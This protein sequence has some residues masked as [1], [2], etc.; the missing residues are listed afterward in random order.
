MGGRSPRVQA[1]VLTVLLSTACAPTPEIEFNEPPVAGIVDLRPDDPTTDQDLTALITEEATDPDGDDLRLTWTFTRNGTAWAVPGTT[2]PM[3]ETARGQEWAVTVVASDGEWESAPFSDSVIIA[4]S[5]PVVLSAAFEDTSPTTRDLLHVV[6]EAA[7]ADDDSLAW[8]TRWTVDGE[9]YDA[10]ADALEVAS[11]ATSAG[12]TWS[13]SVAA[14]DG[15]DVGE[16]LTASVTIANTGPVIESV[17]I[18]PSEPTVEDSIYASVL[19]LFDPDDADDVTLTV[20]W[21]IDG[22]LTEEDLLAAPNN[23]TSL[24]TDVVRGQSLQVTA[25]PA[26]GLVTGD[27]LTSEAVTVENALPVLGYVD[28]SPPDGDELTVFTCS[29]ESAT[30]ADGDEI[31]LDIDWWVSGS[32]ASSGAE[33]LDGEDFDKGDELYCEVTPRDGYDEGASVRS[34]TASISN[35]LPEFTSVEISPSSPDVEDTVSAAT[36]GWYDADGDPEGYRYAWYVEGTH[37]ASAST[38]ELSSYARGEEVEVEVTADDGAELGTVITSTAIEIDNAEPTLSSVALSPTNPTTTDDLTAF[39]SG[40][41]DADGDDE[42]YVYAW[43]VERSEGPA[44]QHSIGLMTPARLD[45]R[46]S[47]IPRGSCRA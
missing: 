38:L 23:L 16:A 3:A 27:T 15:I 10:A 41:S 31:S 5:P 37:V 28:L 11:T 8:R 29:V 20:E 2:V 47:S 36:E 24:D 21:Y 17:H 12:Q 34:S 13:V 43:Y 19:G 9:P 45:G 18:G 14:D 25:T 46:C 42:G 35:S 44:R 4:N 32:R 1:G 6:A 22:V 40:W 26:D 39:P 30:D 7:D 33:Q